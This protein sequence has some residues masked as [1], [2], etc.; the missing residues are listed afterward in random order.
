MFHPSPHAWQYQ[1]VDA[2][3]TFAWVPIAFERQNGQR[4]GRNSR[5]SRRSDSCVMQ[6]QEYHVP[7]RPPLARAIV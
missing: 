4:S 6:D 2:L 5:S 1:Y 7:T 3:M